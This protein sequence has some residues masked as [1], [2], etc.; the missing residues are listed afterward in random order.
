[1]NDTDERPVLETESRNALQMKDL[2]AATELT[3]GSA[4]RTPFIE[5]GIAPYNYWCP[6]C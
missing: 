6:G 5:N 3:R 4:L 2:G 1:M